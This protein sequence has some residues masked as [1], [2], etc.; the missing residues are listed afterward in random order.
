M[1]RVSKNISTARGDAGNPQRANPAAPRS[2]TTQ[3]QTSLVK[4]ASNCEPVERAVQTTTLTR[5]KRPL[6]VTQF[7]HNENAA[8]FHLKWQ[9]NRNALEK[10]VKS[11]PEP[12]R[13]SAAQRHNMLLRIID[14]FQIPQE[15]V[16][17]SKD[18]MEL[19]WPGKLFHVR[20]L[21]KQG[22]MKRL[23]N[24]ERPEHPSKRRKTRISDYGRLPGYNNPQGVSNEDAN[25]STKTMDPTL[26]NDI[27]QLL[28]S[29]RFKS[30]VW[31]DLETQMRSPSP[32]I[33]KARRYL[34]N[35]S[36]RLLYRMNKVFTPKN[37][38][39][40]S[41]KFEDVIRLMLLATGVLRM[42]E[43]DWVDYKESWEDLIA[44]FAA[45][46]PKSWVA[47]DAIQHNEELNEEYIGPMLAPAIM[48]LKSS[49]CITQQ[50]ALYWKIR[51]LLYGQLEVQGHWVD[52]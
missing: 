21:I 12:A 45:V 42:R 49:P 48:E 51:T 31:N 25:D 24:M 16:S 44:R 11:I 4:P 19:Q 41:G 29:M 3:G 22:A 35:V 9:D 18:T 13:E 34:Q 15:D 27:R 33:G 46:E 26:A 2:K 5:P 17:W 39:I 23:E 20:E 38:K 43:V 40:F 1:K 8:E 7:E 32:S 36:N 37:N 28:G 52:G 6:D 30:D 10:Y 50:H 14:H 47:L